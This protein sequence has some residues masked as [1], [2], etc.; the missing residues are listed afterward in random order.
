VANAVGEADEDGNQG[1]V[2]QVHRQAWLKLR[3]LSD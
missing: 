1:E 2:W 3:G